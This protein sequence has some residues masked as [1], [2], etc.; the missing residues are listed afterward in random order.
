MQFRKGREAYASKYGRALELHASGKS[1]SEIAKELGISYS[2]AYHWIKGIRK[3]EAG[4]IREF[5]EFLSKQGPCPAADVKEKFPKH[6]ELY[7]TAASRGSPLRRHV[8]SRPRSFGEFAV[9][10]YLEGQD[11]ALKTKIKAFMEIISNSKD[12][13]KN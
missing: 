7:H 10:Y 11:D 1:V 6:N 9:W 13:E 12:S 5:E 8:L 2:A 3:P 4:N